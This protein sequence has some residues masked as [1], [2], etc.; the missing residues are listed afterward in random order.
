[1]YQSNTILLAASL[2][3]ILHV[4]SSSS[5][6]PTGGDAFILVSRSYRA[7]KPSA[8]RVAALSFTKRSSSFFYAASLPLETH[9]KPYPSSNPT[10]YCERSA[11]NSNAVSSMRSTS[12]RSTDRSTSYL[13]VRRRKKCCCKPRALVLLRN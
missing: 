1:M 7:I 6:V 9:D 10:R 3:T 13:R 11:S 2:A 4:Q 8:A 5:S 12:T